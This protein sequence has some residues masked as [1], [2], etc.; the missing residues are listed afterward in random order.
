MI[1]AIALLHINPQATVEYM[2]RYG[3][4]E[5]FFPLCEFIAVLAFSLLIYLEFIY[6]KSDSLQPREPEM[7]VQELP[8]IN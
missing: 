3:F 4:E 6:K 7:Q 8:L 5:E 2:H 1:L